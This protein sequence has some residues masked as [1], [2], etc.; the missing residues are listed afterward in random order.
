LRSVDSILLRLETLTPQLAALPADSQAAHEL[1]R[2][3]SEELP[4]LVSGYQRVPRA[5]KGKP[6]LGGQ[7]PDRQLVEG[8]A[9][10]DEQIEQMHARLAAD[11]LRALATQQRYLELKYKGDKKLE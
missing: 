6:T 1:K 2:L 11:D 7:T 4:E 5:L 8:L 9:T 10:I 3:L